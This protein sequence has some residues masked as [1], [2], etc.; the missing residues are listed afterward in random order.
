M[1]NII[2][3]FATVLSTGY[4][5]PQVRQNVNTESSI[6]ALANFEANRKGNTVQLSWVA[7]HERDVA[8]HEIQK[9]ANGSPFRNIGTLKAQND[10]NSYAYSFI[11]ATP[12]PGE[13]YYR[14][15]TVDKNGNATFSDI[16][17]VNDGLGRTNLR[18]LGNPVQGGVLN[19]QLA[20]IASGKYFISLYNST[21]EKVF[22][23]SL[24]LSDG[25]LT[26]TIN[27]P[28]TLGNGTYYLEF[29]NGDLRIN[30][31]LMLQ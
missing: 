28:R 3:F 26:E 12:V 21:G 6:S 27:L 24:N 4:V 13:N 22:A 11:D 2:L 14:L 17:N 18:V 8:S 20:N 16:L 29:C 25:S 1:K 23:H 19:L 10:V 9:S 15:R 30:R 5:F 7:L 31:Q